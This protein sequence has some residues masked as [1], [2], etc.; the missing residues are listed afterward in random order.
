MRD[1]T[2]NELRILLLLVALPEGHG[3]TQA[4]SRDDKLAANVLCRRGYAHY[5]EAAGIRAY[6]PTFEGREYAATLT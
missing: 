3:T 2:E 4:L 1:L 5:I 6:Y